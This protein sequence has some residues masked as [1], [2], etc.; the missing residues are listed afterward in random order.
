MSSALEQIKENKIKA[1][2]GSIV[3]AEIV[4]TLASFYGFSKERVTRAL[5]GII[6][7]RGLKIVDDYQSFLSIELYEK[8]NIKYIDAV[9]A[10]YKIIQEKKCCIVSYDRDFDKLPLLKKE[11]GDLVK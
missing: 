3:L 11:P 7:L 9:I 5:R 4:W 6:N 2:T 1:I 8:Y 10:S